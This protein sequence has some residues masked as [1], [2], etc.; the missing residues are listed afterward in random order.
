MLVGR[1]MAGD[2]LHGRDLFA[3]I[4]DTGAVLA[5]RLGLGRGVADSISQQ[6]ERWD[7]RGGPHGLARAEIALP[8]RGSEVATQALLLHQAGG[9]DAAMS[10][11]RDRSGGWCAPAMAEAFRR[12]G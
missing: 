7:G 12:H 11:L 6:F 2:L 4:C 8:A 10:M 9:A 1:A 3:S 5:G